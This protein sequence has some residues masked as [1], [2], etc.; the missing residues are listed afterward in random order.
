MNGMNDVIIDSCILKQGYLFRKGFVFTSITRPGNIYDGIV[1]KYPQDISC[2]SPVIGSSLRSLSEHIE[3]INRYKIEKALIIA[4]SIDFIAECPTLKHLNIVPA[5]NVGDEFDYSP[6]YKMPQI[7]SLSCATVYGLRN[8][9]SSSIDCSKLCG[10]EDIHIIN[11]GY[12]NYNEIETLKSLGLTGYKKLDLSEAFSS[13][14][15]DTLS[16]FQSKIST[17]DGIQ[18]SKK[19]QCL[20]LYNN[21]N[22]QDISVLRNVKN[23]LKALHIENCP[24]IDDFSVLSELENVE[25]LRLSGSNELQNLDFI[26]TMKKLKTFIFNMNVKDGDLTP[27]LNLSY[28]FSAKNRKHYN[29]K[30]KDLPKIKYVRGNENIE[31]WRR[32]K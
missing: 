21:R 9:F 25:L 12:K 6:L 2:Y 29:L 5:G 32:E 4:E 3:I 8:E 24:K 1:I 23:T 17:L 13:S 7:K 20:Y 22:L 19:M 14:I 16:V 15:L 10:L 28:V 30:D 27:C 31:Q 11:S 26:K 18:K